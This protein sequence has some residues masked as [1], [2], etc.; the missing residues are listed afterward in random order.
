MGYDKLKVTIDLEEYNILNA[1]VKEL[2]AKD[3]DADKVLYKKDIWALLVSARGMNQS[4]DQELTKMG[5][6]IA[7]APDLGYR[8]GEEYKRMTVNAK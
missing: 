3:Q 2:E 5:I 7:I 1:K 6:S 4:V 8:S